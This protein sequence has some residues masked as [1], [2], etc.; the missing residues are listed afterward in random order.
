MTALAGKAGPL[1]AGSPAAAAPRGPV[2]AA[3]APQ[4][5]IK[6]RRVEPVVPLR[7]AVAVS[8]QLFTS[9]R[10]EDIW[11]KCFKPAC[12]DGDTVVDHR[13]RDAPITSP[14]CSIAHIKNHM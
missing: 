5:Q 10:L 11:K 6:R 3:A 2:R 13:K 12:I 1:A 7:Y 8:V 14:V 9:P 4:T